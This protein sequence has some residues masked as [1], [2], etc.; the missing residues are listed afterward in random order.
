MSTLDT[1]VPTLPFQDV[2][3][4]Q[5]I[6]AIGAIMYTVRRSKVLLKPSLDTLGTWS[7]VPKHTLGNFSVYVVRFTHRCMVALLGIAAIIQHPDFW[8]D[9]T[10]MWTNYPNHPVT[11]FIQ[12]MYLLQM[13]YYVDDLLTI[14]QDAVT[15]EKK[16]MDLVMN[17]VHHSTTAHH[18]ITIMLLVG[19]SK[20][21]FTRVGSMVSTLHVMSDIPKDMAKIASKLGWKQASQV[22][23]VLMLVTWFLTRLYWYPKLCLNSVLY[24]SFPVYDAAST[25]TELAQIEFV[26]KLLTY[27]LVTIQVLNFLWFLF[28]LKMLFEIILKGGIKDPTAKR[29]D[30]LD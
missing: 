8:L 29:E 2:I 27:L 7:G 23:F 21:N 11:D 17:L 15:K 16:V 12:C 9:T 10:L 14:V 28:L 6:A 5:S 18:V 30:R 20:Y 1:I 3:S 19:S 13:A 24:E 26:K 25:Q 4:L 22:S